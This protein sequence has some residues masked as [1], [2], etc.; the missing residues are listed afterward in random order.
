MTMLGNVLE[1]CQDHW[2]DDYQGAPTDG[3]AWEDRDAGALRVLRGGSW[4][5]YA[6]NLSAS[7]RKHDP[8]GSRDDGIGFRCTRVRS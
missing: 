4:Y 6:H 8:P 1:W 3:A 7:C 5:S 2:H